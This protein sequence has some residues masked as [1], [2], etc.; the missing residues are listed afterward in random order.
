MAFFT[1]TEFL[2]GTSSGLP[3]NSRRVKL[4]APQDP[5]GVVVLAAI[6]RDQDGIA[7]GLAEALCEAGIAVVLPGPDFEDWLGDEEPSQNGPLFR[8]LA[9]LGLWSRR[10]FGPEDLPL[11]LLAIGEA[12]APAAGAAAMLGHHLHSI[13][14]CHA[15]PEIVEVN[16][17]L[18]T[19]PSLFLSH[20]DDSLDSDFTDE[21]A[22]SMGGRSQKL[23]GQKLPHATPLEWFKRHF[24]DFS[25]RHSKP[26]S[27]AA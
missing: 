10:A 14:L 27:L 13:L 6:R 2:P 9:E 3:M 26:G 16:L 20:G 19:A 21:V 7:R 23:E 25:L 5:G 24:R 15:G 22:A 4:F 18:I 8:K 17:G 1:R 11:G 12:S